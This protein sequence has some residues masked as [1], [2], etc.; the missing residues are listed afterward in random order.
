MAKNMPP[1]WI[2]E[3]VLKGLEMETV[4]NIS[5]NRPAKISQVIRVIPEHSLLV[6]NDKESAVC[7]ALTPFCLATLREKQLDVTSLNNCFVSIREWHVSS[8]SICAGD[9]DMSQFSSLS[10]SFPIGVILFTFLL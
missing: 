7:V 5:N 2:R 8:L 1:P 10:I 6:I 3:A 4:N 9:R